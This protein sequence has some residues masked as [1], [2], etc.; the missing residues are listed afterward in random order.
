VAPLRLVV[1]PLSMCLL[2]GLGA[3]AAALAGRS[4]VRGAL[5]RARDASGP[6][7]ATRSL[8]VPAQTPFM[9]TGV[10][11]KSGESALITATGTISYGSQNPAC[12]GSDIPPDGCGA[13]TI[14]PVG[15]GCGALVGRLG[16][17][18]A[19]LVGD[20]KT[21][22]GPGVLLLGIN[23]QKGA[24]GDNSGAFAVTITITA[25]ATPPAPAPGTSVGKVTRVSGG[26]H[27]WVQGKDGRLTP[28]Q[29]GTEL[30]LGDTIVTGDNTTVTIDFTIGGRAGVNSN[31]EVTVVSERTVADK[32]T[33]G[34][35][36]LDMFDLYG[37]GQRAAKA[38]EPVEIQTNG[39]VIGIKG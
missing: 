36:I 13:E 19:F 18:P 9:S 30:G 27:A 12:S 6:A 34:P 37:I 29:P 3:G 10:T 14:C 8:S 7:T 28:L 21:V 25:G 32:S 1:V 23:D 5:T 16:D 31:S 4:P 20:R 24:F 35:A 39:G 33:N 2:L 17:G 22:D 11:L 38:R 26:R 15:G